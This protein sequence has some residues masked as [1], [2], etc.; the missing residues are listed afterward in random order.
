ML[1]E[2]THDMELVDSIMRHPQ[3]WP[4]VHDD[5]AEDWQP[6]DHEGIFWMLIT[7]D[8]GEVGGVFMVHATN[9]YCYEMHTCLLPET[10][11]AEAARA[12]QLLAGWVFRETPAEKLVTNVPAYNR[13]ARRFAIAGGMQQEGVNRAS[14]MKNGVMVDQIMLGITKEELICQQQ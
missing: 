14:F 9:S 12:A 11:G 2:R 8:N 3:I 1:I 7:R 4:H 10:W 13:A 5:G 6:V